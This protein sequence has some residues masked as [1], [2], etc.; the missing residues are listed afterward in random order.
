MGYDEQQLVG[1]LFALSMCQVQ[2]APINSLIGNIVCLKADTWLYRNTLVSKDTNKTSGDPYLS[3]CSIFCSHHYFLLH[4]GILP[5][6][7][8]LPPQRGHLYRLPQC[9]L[10]NTSQCRDVLGKSKGSYQSSAHLDHVWCESVAQSF[11]CDIAF[12]SSAFWQALTYLRLYR[13]ICIFYNAVMQKK[14]QLYFNCL[15]LMENLYMYHNYIKKNTLLIKKTRLPFSQKENSRKPKCYFQLS[16]VSAKD[17]FFCAINKSN[18][19]LRFDSFLV[20][21]WFMAIQPLAENGFISLAS[22][23]I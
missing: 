23:Y 15:I 17:K 4:F 6:R 11:K 12:Q 13:R 1:D 16:D 9:L 22:H 7:R 20:Y 5:I 18:D 2:G 8:Q 3:S 14:Q 10:N 19:L 21:W